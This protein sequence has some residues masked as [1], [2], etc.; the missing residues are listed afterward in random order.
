MIKMIERKRRFDGFHVKFSKDRDGDY[1]AFFELLPNISAIAKTRQK[2]MNE[3]KIVWEM[4]KET[5]SDFGLDIPSP[6]KL[7][8]NTQPIEI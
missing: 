8:S 1:I 6:S 5:Y 3:L 7:T 4:I 2:A